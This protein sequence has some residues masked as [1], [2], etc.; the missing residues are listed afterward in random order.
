MAE[1]AVDAAVEVAGL[2]AGPCRTRALPL[3]GAAT[4]EALR[5]VSAPPALLARYGTEAR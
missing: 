3:V 2:D 5:K 1:D 4:P